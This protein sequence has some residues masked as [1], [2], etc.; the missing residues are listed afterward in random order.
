[1]EACPA[2][3][4][5]EK[6]LK[7]TKYP[8]LLLSIDRSIRMHFFLNTYKIERNKNSHI[9]RLKALTIMRTNTNKRH[10]THTQTYHW[11]VHTNTKWA[12]FLRNTNNFNFILLFSK[13]KPFSTCFIIIII[14]PTLLTRIVFFYLEAEASIEI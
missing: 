1:M 12:E 2:F 13:S 5:D 8:R 6:Q 7:S 11:S 3:N 14:N 9:C 10:D 4:Y